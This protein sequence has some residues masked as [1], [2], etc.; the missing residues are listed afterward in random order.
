M[1]NVESFQCG[2]RSS[3]LPLIIVSALLLISVGVLAQTTISTGSIVGTVAD[4]TGAVVTGAKVSITNKG[5]GQVMTTTTTSSGTFASGA[6]TPGEYTVRIEGQGFKTAQLS[7]LVEVNTTASANLKLAL[8]ESSQVIEV[9]ASALAVNTEQATVQGVLTAQQIENLPINGRNFLDLA[10]LEPGVQIQDGQTFDPTKNGFSSI[11]I[12]GRAGRTA[13][14]EVDGVDISDENVGTTTQNIAMDSIQEFQIGQSSLDLS[15]ELTSSGTVNVTTKS[16]TNKVHGDAFGLFRDKRAGVANFPG[17]GDNPYQRDSFGGS[18][19]GPIVKD[20]LF[21]FATA[22]RT[23]Q[24]IFAPVVFNAPFVA[25]S[26]GYTS[27]FRENEMSGKLDYQFKQGAHLFYKISYD[28]NKAVNSFGGSNYQPF[29]NHDSTPS[30]AVGFAFNT[31]G[32]T[33]SFRFAYNHFYNYIADAVSGT[34]IFDPAPAINLA[35]GGGSGFASGIN[36]L[37]PQT[38]VQVNKE[39]K[40]DGSTV[41][42]AHVLRYGIGFNDIQGWS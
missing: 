5:T 35:F 2:T 24:D 41:W 26:G 40:Y 34:S 7:V 22:E 14:I 32:F 9:Q 12:G 38:T 21:F 25:L 11:S 17:G 4:P 18:V 8:G 37:A 20:H 33:H 36:L 28:E 23:K 19:G 27:P 31:G 29:K 6:L 16:G 39:I 3:L 13:R 15:S 10:Q 42:R 30:H 1:L